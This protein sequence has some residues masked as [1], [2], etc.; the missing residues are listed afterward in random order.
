MEAAEGKDGVLGA[1]A[2]AKAKLEGG[3]GRVECCAEAG[4]NDEDIH[5]AGD[6]E[7]GDATVVAT[8][9][10]GAFF[11][12]GEDEGV[13]PFSRCSPAAPNSE[14]DAVEGMGGMG[15]TMLDELG[16]DS[17][18][19]WGGIAQGLN[20]SLDF[21]EGWFGITSG[22][23]GWEMGGRRGEWLRRRGRGGWGDGGL[24]GWGWGG[25]GGWGRGLCGW[26]GLGKEV[27]KENEDE[28]WGEGCVVYEEG[29]GG[30]KEEGSEEGCSGDGI[31]GGFRG[32]GRAGAGGEGGGEEEAVEV[33][34]TAWWEFW[35]G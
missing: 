3:E 1:P 13:F 20:G 29:Q 12:E 28:H 23:G 2:R 24:G 8:V 31:G 26:G 35:R 6:G 34:E 17:I 10:F 27:G 19:S 14:D 7:E 4:E 15:T 9:G 30:A 32:G 18:P 21:G 33:S 25:M 5:F 16:R 11:V 22:G